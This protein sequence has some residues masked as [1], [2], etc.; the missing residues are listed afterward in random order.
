MIQA[1]INLKRSDADRNA[2]I[3]EA[4]GDL[5]KKLPVK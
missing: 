3:S 2:S 5:F 1:N 4:I